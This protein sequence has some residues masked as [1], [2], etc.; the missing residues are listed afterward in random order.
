MVRWANKHAPKGVVYVEFLI[1][2]WPMMLL[3]LGLAH[4][5][6]MYGAHI[7]VN[8]AAARA[9]RAA[10]VILPDESEDWPDEPLTIGD[11]SNSLNA[12]ENAPPAG[13]LHAIRRAA[14]MT[15]APISPGLTSSGNPVGAIADLLVGY[16]WTDH[17][18]AVTFP[19]G[20]G[21]Y[22]TTFDATGP[23]TAQVTYLYRCPIP[24]VDKIICNRYWGADTIL[25]KDIKDALENAGKLGQALG[26]LESGIS[27]E[28]RRILDTVNAPVLVGLGLGVELGRSLGVDLGSGGWRF[29]AMQ[30]ERI[31]PM[32]GKVPK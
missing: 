17:A 27:D 14:R 18:V 29:L 22:R 32:Q 16:L 12:Y 20:D 10:I 1:V 30:A 5:G 19:N 9:A 21:D 4:I 31:L 26:S 25:S 13:R 2:F 7:M 24:V 3:W 15:L 8:H 23:V 6:L 28:S 11:D